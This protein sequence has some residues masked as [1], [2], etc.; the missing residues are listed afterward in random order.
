[1]GVRAAPG[2]MIVV[3]EDQDGGRLPGVVVTAEPP[4]R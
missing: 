4:T 3:V 2:T 1:M